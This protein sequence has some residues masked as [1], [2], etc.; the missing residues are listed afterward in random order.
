MICLD[1]NVL[2]NAHRLDAPDHEDYVD[3]LVELANGSEPVGLADI[4]LSGFLRVVTNRRVFKV[5]TPTD[6]ALQ[7]VSRLIDSPAGM[8]LRSGEQH[9]SIFI[10]LMNAMG[11][12]GN[13][14]PDAYIAAFAIENNAT[15]LSADRGFA[16]FERLRWR[17]PLAGN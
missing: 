4:V 12:R 3:L 6:V 10:D 17:H 1:V 5:P 2:V 14:V 11:A 7:S 8:L 16:R 9:W 13:D 15:L